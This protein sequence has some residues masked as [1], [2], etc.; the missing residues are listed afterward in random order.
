MIDQA[1]AAGEPLVT[2][3]GGSPPSAAFELLVL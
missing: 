3:A 1:L 2:L